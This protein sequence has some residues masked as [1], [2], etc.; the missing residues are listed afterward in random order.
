M[1]LA[2]MATDAS[3]NSGLRARRTAPV[4]TALTPII[5]ARLNALGAEHDPEAHPLLTVREGDQGRGDL[6]PAGC[7][8]GEEARERLRQ[9]EPRAEVVEPIGE[10]AR[11]PQGQG[12]GSGEEQDGGCKGHPF[13][14][15]LM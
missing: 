13:N 14:T 9:A 6:R 10:D 4:K 7:E 12:D 2:N 11:R 15:N 5:A 3:I 1:R 8:R